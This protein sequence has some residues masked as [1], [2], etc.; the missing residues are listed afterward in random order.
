MNTA[1]TQ[2]HRE[3]LA[4]LSALRMLVKEVG[5]NYLAG[6]QSEAARI[7]QA[8]RESNK[9]SRKKKYSDGHDVKNNPVP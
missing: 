9:P 1:F 8:S 6:L 7:Q 5:G 3:L 4:A 2:T